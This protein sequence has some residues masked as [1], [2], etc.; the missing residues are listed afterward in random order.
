MAEASQDFQVK[1]VN[2]GRISTCVQADGSKCVYAK[3]ARSLHAWVLHG[4]CARKRA[5]CATSSRRCKLFPGIV[6]E[7][8][9][10][11]LSRKLCSTRKKAA[12]F[13]FE[14]EETALILLFACWPSCSVLRS[15]C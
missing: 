13:V 14:F 15:C 5:Q 10:R 7:K 2:T 4:F 9:F 12:P 1:L 6:P 3:R 11:K 8:K